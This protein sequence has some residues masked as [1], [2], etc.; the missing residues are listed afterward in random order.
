[1]KELILLWLWNLIVLG[2][3]HVIIESWLLRECIV[4]DLRRVSVVYIWWCVIALNLVPSW[5]AWVVI[6]ME[7]LSIVNILESLKIISESARTIWTD[8]LWLLHFMVSSPFSSDLQ[9]WILFVQGWWRFMVFR[10]L[11]L[12]HELGLLLLG[13]LRNQLAAYVL[14]VRL[15][16]LCWNGSINW[17]FVF[18]CILIIM[19]SVWWVSTWSKLH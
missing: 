16:L 19:I 10:C 17:R 3:N 15:V 5:Y 6:W 2:A 18:S 14:F 8:K 4:V 7:V 1:M 12:K 13:R 9:W 11:F